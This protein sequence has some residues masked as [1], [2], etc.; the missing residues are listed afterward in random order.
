MGQEFRT[1]QVCSCA[2]NPCL[3]AACGFLD[4]PDVNENWREVHN[5]VS[6]KEREGQKSLIF[7]IQNNVF[8]VIIQSPMSHR[9]GWVRGGGEEAQHNHHNF[10][11]HNE[12]RGRVVVIFLT[13]LF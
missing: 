4:Y 5:F 8:L 1:G 7:S 3:N 10:R 11:F 6:V 2:R 13:C 9:D 12:S